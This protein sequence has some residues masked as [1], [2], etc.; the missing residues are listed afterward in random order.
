MKKK[1]TLTAGQKRLAKANKSG[2]KS[3]EFFFKKK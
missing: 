1:K 2:M 3:L